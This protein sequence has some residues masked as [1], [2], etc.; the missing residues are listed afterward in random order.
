MQ[1]L[2]ARNRMQTADVALALRIEVV[3]YEVFVIQ[4][5]GTRALLP[6]IATCHERP[7]WTG[8]FT[9]VEIEDLNGN[10]ISRQGRPMTGMLCR[11]AEQHA[12]VRQRR[13]VV[14][15]KKGLCV[16]HANFLQS[17]LGDVGGLLT[18]AQV[19]DATRVD[20]LGPGFGA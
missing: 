20:L 17:S 12:A 9:S 16:R 3:K 7:D 11:M 6:V 4:P 13:L 18:A 19:I 15:P 2:L 1:L 14:I 8:V 5:M 10:F